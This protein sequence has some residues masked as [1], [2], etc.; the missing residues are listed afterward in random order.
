MLIPLLSTQGQP[1]FP[2]KGMGTT[3]QVVSNPANEATIVSILLPVS[4]RFIT[5]YCFRG[6]NYKPNSGHDHRTE[7][8]ITT[9]EK[10][11]IS[12]FPEKYLLGEHRVVQKENSNILK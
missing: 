5:F 12:L 4:S 3:E 2:L 1:S 7:Q 9:D 8:G 10:N 11:Y 6:W